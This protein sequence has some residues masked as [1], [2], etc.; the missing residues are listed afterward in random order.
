MNDVIAI[1]LESQPT[2]F[3]TIKII[4]SIYQSSSKYGVWTCTQSQTFNFTG[5]FKFDITRLIKYVNFECKAN[6]FLE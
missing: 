4:Y 6:V 1:A 3:S 5:L 2:L